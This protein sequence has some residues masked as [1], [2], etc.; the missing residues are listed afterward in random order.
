MAGFIAPP[1]WTAVGVVTTGRQPPRAR[2]RRSFRMPEAIAATHPA[3]VPDRSVGCGDHVV[4]SARFTSHARSRAPRRSGRSGRGACRRVLGLAT[5]PPSEGPEV[6]LTARWLDQLLGSDRSDREV[7]RRGRSRSVTIRL[8]AAGSAP[9]PAAVA[10]LAGQ[11]AEQFNWERL[12][13]LATRS[14]DTDAA[15]TRAV[16]DWMDAGCFARHM[17]VHR[18]PGRRVAH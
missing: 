12:R 17:T 6:W 16:A 8:I 2:R 10:T 4:D 9:T 5:A 11:A 7:G 18:A 1:E 15:M 14:Q 13:L 3:H